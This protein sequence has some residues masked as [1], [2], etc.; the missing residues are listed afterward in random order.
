M[1]LEELKAEAEERKS[2]LLETL[3]ITKKHIEAHERLERTQEL[4]ITFL[5]R[6]VQIVELELKIWQKILNVS[7]E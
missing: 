1:N 7:E 3:D 5:H 4:A 2:I 6:T